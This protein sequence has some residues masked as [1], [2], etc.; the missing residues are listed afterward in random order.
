MFKTHAILIICSHVLLEKL[1]YVECLLHA[2][3]NYLIFGV[4]FSKNCFSKNSPFFRWFLTGF[5]GISPV[6]HVIPTGRF[7]TG[8]DR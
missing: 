2:L 8:P 1:D 5:T 6:G 7:P 4:I 3:L